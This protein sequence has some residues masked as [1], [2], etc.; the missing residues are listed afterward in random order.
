MKNF[1]YGRGHKGAAKSAAKVG[2][3]GW[4]DSQPAK[5]RRAGLSSD[6][7]MALGEV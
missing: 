3:S 4:M 5:K 6:A 2:P 1:L 7:P